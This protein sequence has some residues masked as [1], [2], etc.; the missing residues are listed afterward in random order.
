MTP[1]PPVGHVSTNRPPIPFSP[2]PSIQPQFATSP[3]PPPSTQPRHPAPIHPIGKRGT[4]TR[5]GKP[6]LLKKTAV[7]RFNDS[8]QEEN[9]RLNL[10]RKME[11][12]EKMASI[13]LKRYKYDLRYGSTP[14]TS[15]PASAT[16]ASTTKEDKQ[17]EI[18]HLQI[19]LAELTRDNSAHAHA[20]VSTTHISSSQ[21]PH[22]SSSH[23]SSSHASSS[24]ASSSH[25]SSSRMRY[26]SLEDASTPSSGISYLSGHSH[27]DNNFTTSEDAGHYH[28]PNGEASGVG[29][30]MT[31]WPETY[32]F[33]A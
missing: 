15:T 29:A 25:A 23:A 32:N 20:H 27:N 4:A 21:M 7:D 18:L 17:I 16:P 13:R 9:R 26:N 30:D 19:R 11:H 14:G 6:T 24:H 12:D 2:V 31:S 28:V 10:K 22:A 5:H 8:R 33:A 3:S 1:P